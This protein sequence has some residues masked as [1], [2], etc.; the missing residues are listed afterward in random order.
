MAH[1][2]HDVSIGKQPPSVLNAVV[3]IPRGS[4]AK[5]EID[6]PTGFIRL[7]RI[8]HGAMAYPTHYGIIPQT[9]GEDGDP[10]DILILTK[11]ILAPLTLVTVRV[12]GVMRM[13]D[14]NIP[15]DKIIG[16]AETD[17]SV[18]HLKNVS[19]LTDFERQ[20]LRDFFENYTNLEGKEVTVPA[21]LEASAAFEI[22]DACI[23]NYRNHFKK[24]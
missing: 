10:L 3:E 23:E 16:I 20:E 4:R 6:K 17:P 9:L 1:P 19:D 13:I 12:I 8:L 11:E 21:F 24:V 2:W 7:D 5:Y 14:Q 22:I 15:D 18:S